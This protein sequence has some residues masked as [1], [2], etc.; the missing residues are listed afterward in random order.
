M[1]RWFIVA[2]LVAVIASAGA[3]WVALQ[4]PHP[5]GLVPIGVFGIIAAG[6]VVWRME[7]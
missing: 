5:W 1:I 7:R 2:M 3:L 6:A 4:L